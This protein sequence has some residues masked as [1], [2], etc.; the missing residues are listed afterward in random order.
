MLDQK[1]DVAD[2]ARAAI[3][4][5]RTLK[6]QRLGVRHCSKPSDFD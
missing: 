2:T 5:E 1:Q 6:R 3:L 4:D